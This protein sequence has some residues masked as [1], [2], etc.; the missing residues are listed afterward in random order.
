VRTEVLW[1]QLIDKGLEHLILQQGTQ[2]EAEGLIMGMLQDVAYRIQYQIV[3]DI[4]WNT[5]RVSAKDL[6]SG[7][8]FT[9]TKNGNEWLDEQ[10][11]VIES[12]RGCSDVD[13]K[14]TPFTNTLPINRLNLKQNESKEIAVVY[15][16]IPELNLSKF[17][18]RYT[19]LSK[20]KDGGVYRYESLSS[21][22]T[23]ELKVD[24]DGLVV[25]YPG[26]FKMAW[27]QTQT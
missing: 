2:I 21:G 26:I 12:L 6:L 18:Q 3:C 1:E 23:S 22:F 25:D 17:E 10:D 4:Q 27:K 16:N 20:D 14:V 24:A 7:K 13:I 15:V 11:H 9:L 8:E 19:C 5:Q